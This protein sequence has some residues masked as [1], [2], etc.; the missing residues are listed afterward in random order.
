MA[1]AT[2][3][4][5]WTWTMQ[6][7]S[8]PPTIM[9]VPFFRTS[10]VDIPQLLAWGLNSYAPLMFIFGLL[11]FLK[12]YT[13]QLR[14][15][16]GE[17]FTSTVHIKPSDEAYDMLLAWVSA[18]GLDNTARSTIARVGTKSKHRDSQPIDTKKS[19]HFSPWNARFF[20]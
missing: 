19:L 2:A 3:S 16:F 9:D 7:P 1:S 5:P 12:T 15:L 13:R 17:Y 6:S 18:R 14:S 8:K 4:L 10:H 11:A 20:F